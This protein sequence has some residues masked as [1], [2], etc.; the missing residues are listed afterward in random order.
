MPRSIYTNTIIGECLRSGF[1]VF[2]NDG[3]EDHLC[4]T[5]KAITEII[6]NVDECTI[7][8]RKTA[9]VKMAGTIGALESTSGWFFLVMENDNEEQ[10]S[11][12]STNT[13]ANTITDTIV[14][15]VDDLR[16]AVPNLTYHTF[17][18]QQDLMKGHK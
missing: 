10:I 5:F 9:A 16:D 17:N 3:E 14:N 1:T 11:D 4:K 13:A 8:L 18:I 15:V 2:V 7:F 6:D 12:Y